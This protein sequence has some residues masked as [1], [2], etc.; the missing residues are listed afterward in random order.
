MTER[1]SRWIVPRSVLTCRDLPYPHTLP[2]RDHL[3]TDTA[4]VRTSGI[5]CTTTRTEHSVVRFCSRDVSGRCKGCSE[6]RPA[7]VPGCSC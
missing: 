4:I 2:L 5:F 7:T 6:S 3:S 1:R